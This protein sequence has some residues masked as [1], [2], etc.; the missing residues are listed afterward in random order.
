MLPQVINN[1]VISIYASNFDKPKQIILNSS[2]M[3]LFKRYQY[4]SWALFN[5]GE[6]IMPNFLSREAT[7]RDIRNFRKN[8]NYFSLSKSHEEIKDIYINNNI[9]LELL[10]KYIVSS[11]YLNLLGNKEFENNYIDLQSGINLEANKY[12]N[13]LID[14][15][16]QSIPNGF[17]KNYPISL[18]FNFHIINNTPY[19][20]ISDNSLLELDKINKNDYFGNISTYYTFKDLL[21]LYLNR[22]HLIYYKGEYLTFKE[23][24]K[25]Y[26]PNSLEHWN[27]LLD[28]EIDWEDDDEKEIHILRAIFYHPEIIFVSFK[29]IN[30]HDPK[31]LLLDPLGNLIIELELAFKNRKELEVEIS[32]KAKYP[33]KKYNKELF[34]E[35]TYNL[36]IS[37]ITKTLNDLW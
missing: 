1:K 26:D 17:I 11:D 34:N 20:Y 10:N 3:K 35:I 8:Y 9:S 5:T 27:L 21:K 22:I 24:C 16:D 6:N 28:N 7:L 14:L 2:E 37:T 29:C 13:I 19:E 12:H 25:I 18:L 4:S 15:K 30:I 32:E 36:S 23:L 33:V 31:N